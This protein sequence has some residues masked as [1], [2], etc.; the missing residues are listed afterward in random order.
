MERREKHDERKNMTYS[1]KCPFQ[2]Y[3]I[4]RNSEMEWAEIEYETPRKK[5]CNYPT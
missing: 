3:F 5:F 4:H 1:D 2:R